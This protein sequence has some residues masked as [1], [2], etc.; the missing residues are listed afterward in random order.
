MKNPT[1]V[2]LEH[3][4]NVIRYSNDE[5]IFSHTFL[6][7]NAQVSRLHRGFA[8]GSSANITL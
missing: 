4:S 5:N 3:S 1:E 6:L 7:T 2:T 8:N